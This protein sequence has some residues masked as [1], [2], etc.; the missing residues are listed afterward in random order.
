[1]TDFFSK[2]FKGSK[3]RIL[4][5][6]ES[7]MPK[8]GNTLTQVNFIKFRLRISFKRTLFHDSSDKVMKS[9]S[10]SSQDFLFSQRINQSARINAIN[11]IRL[12]EAEYT[13]E[14][15]SIGTKSRF[16]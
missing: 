16:E 2:I 5:V 15:K 13:K 4:N 1:M 10:D 12:R 8:I 11:S 6:L 14:K 3:L 9:V 7:S